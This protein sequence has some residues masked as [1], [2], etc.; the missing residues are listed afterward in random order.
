VFQP[1]KEPWVPGRLFVDDKEAEFLGMGNG[2]QVFIHPLDPDLVIRVNH[3][4]STDARMEKEF[5]NLKSHS[6]RGR[7]PDAIRRIAIK[8]GYSGMIVERVVSLPD[9]QLAEHAQADTVMVI[10]LLKSLLEDG[11]FMS[12]FGIH[13]IKIGS[14]KG[15]ERRAYLIDLEQID[16]VPLPSAVNRMILR[17]MYT[18]GYQSEESGWEHTYI[19][20]REIYKFITGDAGEN[21]YRAMHTAG[22]YLRLIFATVRFL[23]NFRGVE[24]IKRADRVLRRSAAKK[25]RI[26][27]AKMPWLSKRALKTADTPDSAPATVLDGM[28]EASV[29]LAGVQEAADA[30]APVP[31]HWHY[32]NSSQ[33]DAAVAKYGTAEKDEDGNVHVHLYV[34]E[35][36]PEQGERDAWKF[37]DTLIMQDNS[38]KVWAST[39]R[40]AVV[41]AGEGL[42][43]AAVQKAVSETIIDHEDMAGLDEAKERI[44]R[45][46]HRVAPRFSYDSFLPG[47]TLDHTGRTGRIVYDA[48]GNMI[49]PERVFSAG[50]QGRGVS[51]QAQLGALMAVRNAESVVAAHNLYLYLDDLQNPGEFIRSPQSYNSIRNGQLIVDPKIFVELKMDET[52]IREFAERA[53]RSRMKL[54]IDLK[55]DASL[56]PLYRSLGF[57]GY[58]LA[59]G[60][61]TKVYDFLVN[62]AGKRAVRIRGY[63]NTGDMS[64][65]LR[66]AQEDGKILDRSEVRRVFKEDAIISRIALFDLFTTA[67]LEVTAAEIPTEQKVREVGYA[68]SWEALPPLPDDA[69]SLLTA[70]SG[71]D[72]KEVKLEDILDAMK[73]PAVHPVRVYLEKLKEDVP[74]ERHAELLG[75]LQKTFVIAVVEKMFAKAALNSLAEP[76]TLGLANGDLEPLL[77]RHMIKLGLKPADIV[78]LP[79]AYA[80]FRKLSAGA[81]NADEAYGRLVTHV[82]MLDAAQQAQSQ[83][84]IKLIVEYAEPKLPASMGKEEMPINVRSNKR[85]LSAA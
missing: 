32:I 81:A 80:E 22:Y 3:K 40:G 65:Q 82:Q 83:L 60:A 70:L 29:A 25:A 46:L 18:K 76:K 42:D 28:A 6:R 11:I 23:A 63:R 24:D 12:D 61:E 45:L 71:R 56:V 39:V 72:L 67:L 5:R 19:D 16:K 44:A 75:D 79:D 7:S 62:P 21:A 15:G 66:A 20:H 4:R 58:L 10:D 47:I 73:L 50:L 2:N 53:R 36:F 49:V 35:D 57:P 68:M 69:G 26:I 38:R 59:S 31:L 51:I 43:S 55:S 33:L 14:I 27:S 84:I 78:K 77:G 8:G 37:E 30:A 1:N 17:L 85:I 64:D 9:D 52:A 48:L 34:L 54:Y 41:L 74:A 13:N